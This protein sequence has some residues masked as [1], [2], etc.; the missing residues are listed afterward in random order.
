MLTT[1]LEKIEAIVL[2]ARGYDALTPSTDPDSGSNPTDDMQVDALESDYGATAVQEL[3][4][5]IDGLR[6]DE[7]LDLVALT[8]VGRGTF[9]AGEFDKAI[10]QA[11]QERTLP[12]S[13]YLMGI[14]LL[15]DYLSQGLAELNQLPEYG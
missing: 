14:P 4:D 5:F 15:G 12:T 7:Q 8:W 2:M 6:E 11:A 13:D 10:R 1:N 9:E 3:K